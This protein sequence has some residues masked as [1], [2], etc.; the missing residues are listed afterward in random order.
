LGSL[1]RCNWFS[2]MEATVFL[3]SS[4]GSFCPW[5]LLY[6]VKSES[7]SSTNTQEEGITQG[8]STRRWGPL[9]TICHRHGLESKKVNEARQYKAQKH[10]LEHRG[11]SLL[12]SGRK[13][14]VTAQW[15]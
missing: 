4:I 13:A 7:R 5:F 11:R 10:M 12:N 3:Q 2:N 8:I 15:G 9:E 6:S 1:Y 14:L